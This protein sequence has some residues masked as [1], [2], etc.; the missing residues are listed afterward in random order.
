[1]RK[2]FARV[3]LTVATILLFYV[4]S[5]R[6]QCNAPAPGS[7]QGA[8]S[9]SNVK[10]ITP[11]FTRLPDVR[12]TQQELTAEQAEFLA[13]GPK[14]FTDMETAKK[15]SK[16]TGKPVACW[17]SQSANT[18]DIFKDSRARRVSRE[19]GDTTI[20]VAMGYN[21]TRDRRDAE[22]KPLGAR[23]EISSSNY[24]AT[25]KTAYIPVAKLDSDSGRK[26]LSFARG[27][28]GK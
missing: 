12:G 19:L 27:G 22:G 11:V 28:P 8:P 9:F 23:V 16:L 17:V 13:N 2:F 6:A 20:Q 21:P 10:A 24:E 14:L 4:G 7:S 15:V 1:M 25:A 18:L 26:L 5:V 3:P